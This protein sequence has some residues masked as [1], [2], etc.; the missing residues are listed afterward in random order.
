MLPLQRHMK[1]GLSRS[2]GKIFYF[3]IIFFNKRHIVFSSMELFFISFKPCTLCS[4]KHFCL[5][6]LLT[7]QIHFN[8]ANLGIWTIQRSRVM[9]D[10]LADT[11]SGRFR[12]FSC[13]CVKQCISCRAGTIR[14]SAVSIHIRYGPCRYDTYSIRYTIM[15]TT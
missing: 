1:K 9:F 2:V 10:S 3:Y 14:S 5:F 6:T 13:V 12:Q 15:Y 7:R 4:S 11:H 8:K